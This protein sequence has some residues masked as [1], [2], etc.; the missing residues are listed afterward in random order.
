[1][2][3]LLFFLSGAALSGAVLVLLWAIPVGCRTNHLIVAGG[4]G[5]AASKLDVAIFFRDQK[6]W[7]GEPGMGERVSVH[8]KNS[9]GSISVFID[10]REAMKGGYVFPFDGRDYVI[11]IVDG[12]VF[13]TSV[14]RGWLEL[15]RDYIGCIGG[16]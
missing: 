13:F 1:M 8:M 10:G 16:R 2:K 12:G 14:D 15:A 9:E 11:G 6:V 7:S 4:T 5:P 3:K